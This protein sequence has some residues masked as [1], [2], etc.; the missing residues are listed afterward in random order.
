MAPGR[1]ISSFECKLCDATLETWNSA[2]IPAYRL[3]AEPVKT[4]E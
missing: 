4:S 2:W 1:Q 3:I